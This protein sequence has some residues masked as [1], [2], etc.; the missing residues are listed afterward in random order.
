MYILHGVEWKLKGDEQKC[1]QF[2]LFLE[3]YTRAL[4]V[5]LTEA[6]GSVPPN[7]AKPNK[8][9]QDGLANG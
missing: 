8:S 2:S 1:N 9:R 5:W 6:S 7:R 3:L 4:A